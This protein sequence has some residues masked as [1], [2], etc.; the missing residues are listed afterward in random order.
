MEIKENNICLSFILIFNIIYKLRDSFPEYTNLLDF[1]WLLF[2]SMERFLEMVKLDFDYV[3]SLLQTSLLY[4]RMEDEQ[5]RV[6]NTDLYKQID[7]LRSKIV[8]TKKRIQTLATNKG[9][10]L[11]NKPT[12][13]SLTTTS[14]DQHLRIGNA[15]Q[16]RTSMPPPATVPN[17]RSSR[18]NSGK[19][20]FQW[21][22]LYKGLAKY[23]FCFLLIGYQIFSSSS[24]V[25]ITDKPFKCLVCTKNFPT[26]YKL[27]RHTFSHSGERPYLCAWPN[28]LK[29]FNSFNN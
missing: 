12:T 2:A 4:S 28:C 25:P 9:Q 15:S 5:E 16:A 26:S 21:V 8:E 13:A 22:I 20:A 6:I 24:S 27:N 3:G 17:A 10:L 1:S 19:K 14:N 11:L 18:A 29:R 23:Y 7:T